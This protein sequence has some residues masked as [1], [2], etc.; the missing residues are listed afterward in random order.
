VGCV[1]KDLVEALSRLC[2]SKSRST[3][4]FLLLTADMIVPVTPL[5]TMGAQYGD[6]PLN[7]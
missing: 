3:R 2:R 4:Q 5:F 7:S 6:I 1:I